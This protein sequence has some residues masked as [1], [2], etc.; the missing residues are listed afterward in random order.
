LDPNSVR[1][2]EDQQI[3]VIYNIYAPNNFRDKECCWEEIKVSMNVEENTNVILRGDLNLVLHSNEK[4][5]GIF[6]PDPLRT[7]LE[8][9]M[10]DH[11]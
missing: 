9:I 4:R 7:Q 1:N 3:L 10:H 5:G 2:K 6:S 11:D 8:Y